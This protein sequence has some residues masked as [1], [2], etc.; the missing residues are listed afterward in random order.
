MK[1][2][3][4]RKIKLIKTKIYQKMILLIECL[5]QLFLG[6]TSKNQEAF[7]INI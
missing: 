5:N 2:K 7:L 4:A 1:V 6:A 3:K